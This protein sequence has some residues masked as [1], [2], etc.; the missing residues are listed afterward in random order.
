MIRV[1]ARVT[2]VLRPGIHKI[3]TIASGELQPG[4]DLSL[5]SRVEIE[6]EGG[7]DE[8]C[9]MFRYT[10]AGESCGD[11]WHATLPDAFSQAAFEY[12][13]SESDFAEVAEDAGR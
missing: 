3:G 5:P 9:R 12:G 7:R 10:D 1:V 8:P 6:L 2:R 13:L 4:L 11:T